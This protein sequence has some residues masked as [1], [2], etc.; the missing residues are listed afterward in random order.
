MCDIC[1]NQSYVVI[2]QGIIPDLFLEGDRKIKIHSCLQCE[3][4][5]AGINLSG[6]CRLRYLSQ[7]I[8]HGTDS[9]TIADLRNYLGCPEG[10]LPTPPALATYSN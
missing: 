1:P 4:L 8:I 10:L 2:H 3:R 7:L 6:W 5:Y 9:Q